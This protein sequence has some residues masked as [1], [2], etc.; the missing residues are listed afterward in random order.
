[1]RSTYKPNDKSFV[2]DDDYVSPID[3]TTYNESLIASLTRQLD[4]QFLSEMDQEIILV[5]IDHLDDKGFLSNYKAVREDLVQQFNIDHRHVFKCLKVLQSFEP[6]GIAS[7]SINECL[8]NQIES[9]GLDNV[10]DE[11]N[12]KTLVKDFLDDVSE[13]KFDFCTQLKID[14]AQLILILTLFPI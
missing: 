5:L 3:F 7:R 11:K 1:M 10:D 12:L 4:A 13:K 8:W 14:Q 6:D 9:Y 2:S